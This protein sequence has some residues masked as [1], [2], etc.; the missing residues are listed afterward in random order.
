MVR[1]Q[2]RIWFA[3]DI[4]PEPDGNVEAE[5]TSSSVDAD[6]SAI[7]PQASSSEQQTTAAAAAAAA[8]A[9]VAAFQPQA[10]ALTLW[11][12]AAAAGPAG[13][14]F[15]SFPFTRFTPVVTPFPCSYFP[16]M[17]LYPP[18]PVAQP[19]E[20][21]ATTDVHADSATSPSPPV[22]LPKST[23]LGVIP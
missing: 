9:A 3:D 10:A 1:V 12:G 21:P 7:S 18:P 16:Q 11:A 20:Q 13:V 22:L 5:V 4:K 17:A 19:T 14:G 15:A 6:N 2:V 23:S 8:A